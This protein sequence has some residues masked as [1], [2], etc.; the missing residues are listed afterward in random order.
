[1]CY[2]G[3]GE[4]TPI[5]QVV[6]LHET[7]SCFTFGRKEVA[8][9]FNNRNTEYAM[10]YKQKY[11]LRKIAK[12]WLDAAGMIPTIKFVW[13]ALPQKCNQILCQNPFQIFPNPISETFATGICQH[14]QCT[15]K[16]C[17]TKI[18][19]FFYS[20]AN[21]ETPPLKIHF[22]IYLFL[23]QSRNTSRVYGG[24]WTAKHNTLNVFL[25][26]LSWIKTIL[27]FFGQKQRQATVG[28]GRQWMRFVFAAIF[29]VIGGQPMSVGLTTIF[30]S[31]L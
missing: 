27:P 22:D 23:G 25:W 13:S 5:H 14:F 1:M 30:H 8:Q 16:T 29:N 18:Y 24:H 2:A 26:S 19:P 28:V 21:F 15:I 20:F 4:T 31:Q 11:N 3:T 17:T 6:I 10:K 12:G 9:I 7:T